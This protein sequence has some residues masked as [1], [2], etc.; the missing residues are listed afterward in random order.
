MPALDAAL[1]PWHRAPWGEGKALT[2]GGLVLILLALAAMAA[3]F[4]LAAG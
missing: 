2:L 1:R 3:L 4:R